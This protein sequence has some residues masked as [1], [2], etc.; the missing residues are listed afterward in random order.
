MTVVSL[1]TWRALYAVALFC[2]EPLV[3][4]RL[5]LRARREP[6]YGER[7]A[8]RFGRVPAGVP[9][10]PVWIHAV[11]AG[12]V[13]AASRLIG[14]LAASFPELPFLVTSTTPAGSGEIEARLVGRYE[15]LS[16]CYAP[17]DFPRAVDRFF[18]TV[19][20]RL[21]VLVETELWP[22]V[23]ARA[24]RDG[25]P[26]LLVNGRLS[27]RSAARYARVGPLVREML[28]S[29]TVVACQ[30]PDQADRFLALGARPETV[31]CLGNLKFDTPP[32]RVA[33]DPLDP[34]TIPRIG[35]TIGR[36][37]W[38]AGSTHAGEEQLVLAAHRRVR[39]RY[40]ELLLILAPRQPRRGD[41]VAALLRD[42][43]WSFVRRSRQDPVGPETDVLLVDVL[44]ELPGLYGLADVAFVGGSL[45]RAG[46]HNV[47]E[48][49]AW[50]VPLV[51]GPHVFNFADVVA[52]FAAEGALVEAGSAE[53]LA[54]AVGRLLGDPD[55]RARQG[56]AARAVVEAN[57][58][59]FDRIEALIRPLLS[60][61]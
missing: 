8:E 38:I 42:G 49:A 2:A 28:E 27:L 48:P 25:V 44:G 9:T 57:R 17:F 32:P 21:L 18:G 34:A 36:P 40:P 43:G 39:E 47:I 37:I 55:A 15:N 1:R 58:G 46:G 30:Y 4:L 23:L 19:R 31:A 14:T 61:C 51:T 3:R 35:G 26:A 29:L 24:R 60:A 33:A 41:A 16:H 54:G 11:S 53:A 20:P 12:E 13:I 56:R 5:R 52:A 22:N 50:G 10:G 6:A 45:I 59:A 7:R